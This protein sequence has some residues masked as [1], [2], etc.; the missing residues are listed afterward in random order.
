MLDSSTTQTHDSTLC[1]TAASRNGSSIPVRLD[2]HLG[3]SELWCHLNCDVVGTSCIATSIQLTSSGFSTHW[4]K[5]R[6]RR[7][8]GERGKT[9]DLSYR[10][11]FDC[12]WLDV[13]IKRHHLLIVRLSQIL[14]HSPFHFSLL[15]L[16]IVPNTN[17]LRV[18][19]KACLDLAPAS[20]LAVGHDLLLRVLVRALPCIW[21]HCSL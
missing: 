11:A 13:D 10:F 2:Q 14:V 18:L 19:L 9:Q 6:R 12:V 3:I 7:S 5:E 20:Q 21:H 1:T 4:R 16:S 8:E 17:R 15:S